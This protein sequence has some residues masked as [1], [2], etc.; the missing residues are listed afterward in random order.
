MRRL[1]LRQFARG[2]HMALVRVMPKRMNMAGDPKPHGPS[3]ICQ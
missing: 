1:L 3:V 2:D